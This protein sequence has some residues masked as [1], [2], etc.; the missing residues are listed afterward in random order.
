MV[1]FKLGQSLTDKEKFFFLFF[2]I[3]TEFASKRKLW[4]I[5]TI[6]YF[7]FRKHPLIFMYLH[8]LVFETRSFTQYNYFLLEKVDEHICIYFQSKNSFLFSIV[9]FSFKPSLYNL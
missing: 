7:R 3:K 5:K 6:T 1:H 2:T 8:Y 9:F 4:M